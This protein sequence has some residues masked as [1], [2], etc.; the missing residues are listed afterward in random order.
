MYDM[1]HWF[2]WDD[3]F[4]ARCLWVIWMR[5]PFNNLYVTNSGDNVG[6]LCGNVC[7]QY[8]APST[9][10][11]TSPSV[12]PTASPIRTPSA[13]PTAFPT[14]CSKPAEIDR[15]TLGMAGCD[16]CLST[17]WFP[18]WPP[19]RSVRSTPAQNR[20]SNKM[21]VSSPSDDIDLSP[22]SNDNAANN[23]DAS[24]PSPSN[25]DGSNKSDPNV[26]PSDFSASSITSSSPSPEDSIHEPPAK[27]QRLSVA[28]KQR[29]PRTPLIPFNPFPEAKEPETFV[30]DYSLN[31]DVINN[32]ITLGNRRDAHPAL[33]AVNVALLEAT[34]SMVDE[35]KSLKQ[36]VHDQNV[37]KLIGVIMIMTSCRDRQIWP[38][39]H[40]VSTAL[41]C[42]SWTWTK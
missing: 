27:K 25:D 18:Q 6:T 31:Q 4:W 39:C 1:G 34:Q 41:D 24:H 30:A 15:T 2:W 38:E 37:M 28:R 22:P 19:S 40:T 17:L 12:T 10:P 21:N 11:T 9:A 42:A 35:V 13:S 14:S 8:V 16:N 32:L 7:F 5:P 29:T 23:S 33:C 26:S 20:Q 3:L 36:K